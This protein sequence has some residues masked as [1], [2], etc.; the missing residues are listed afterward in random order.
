MTAGLCQ[1]SSSSEQ[2]TIISFTDPTEKGF[3]NLP[4]RQ[5]YAKV[6]ERLIT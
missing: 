1:E 5:R 6:S 3:K 4:D 2:S